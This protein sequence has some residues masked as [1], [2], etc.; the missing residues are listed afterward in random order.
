MIRKLYEKDT[1]V[2]HVD[3]V[4]EILQNNGIIIVPTDTIYAFCCSLNNTKGIERIMELKR[5]HTS[6]LSLL[7]CDLSQV[8]QY[9]KPIPNAYFKLI[10]NYLPGP[11]TFILE[12]NNKVP[13]LFKTN[14]KNVGIRIPDNNIVS[15]IVKS[16][17]SPLVG[18]SI[19]AEDDIIEYLTDPELIHENYAEIV[20]L[21]VDGGFGSNIPSTVIDLTGDEPIVL[22]E[23]AGVI[24]S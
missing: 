13:R 19:H 4:V 10:K 20:N 11:Y 9:V 5:N 6:N 22:R 24:F 3:E 8:S 7:C 14:K 18:T 16:L 23:G 17:G 12:A 1:N 2:K 15:E 21:V